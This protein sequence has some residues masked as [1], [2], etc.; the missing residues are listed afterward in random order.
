MNC[1][2]LVMRVYGKLHGVR[3][4]IGH[5]MSI[6]LCIRCKCRIHFFP[7]DPSLR[8]LLTQHVCRKYNSEKR[9][10]HET[11]LFDWKIEEKNVEKIADILNHF[12]NNL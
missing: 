5:P 9:I 7:F 6:T 8:L 3:D 10:K 2:A 11:L 4:C 1:V 12:Q